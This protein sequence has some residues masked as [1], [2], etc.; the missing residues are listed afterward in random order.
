MKKPL[1]YI[2][3]PYTKPDP[4]EN[5]RNA[6][7][8]AELIERSD[9]CAVVIPH[10]TMLWHLISPANIEKWYERDM[11]LLERCDALMR[12]PGESYGADKEVA[13]AVSH[14]IPTFSWGYG[15]SFREWRS[16]WGKGDE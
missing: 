9:D 8:I 1:I 14:N 5:T 13:F 16:L 11:H 12:L 10:L 4:I 7:R 3:G 6:V 15:V 2:A